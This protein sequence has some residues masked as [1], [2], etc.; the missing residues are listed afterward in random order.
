MTFTEL[1]KE[2]AAKLGV[3]LDDSAADFILWERT[4]FPL[5]TG[6]E[7][8]RRHVYAEVKEHWMNYKP[9]ETG[10]TAWEKVLKDDE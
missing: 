6:E 9:K 1:A 2:E 4:P 3:I 5:V 7:E 10:P 8:L